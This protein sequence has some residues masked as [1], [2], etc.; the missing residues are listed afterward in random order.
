MTA[1]WRGALLLGL[2]LVGL[3]RAEPPPTSTPTPQPCLDGPVAGLACVPGGLFTRGVDGGRHPPA[4]PRARVW[5]GTFYMD[6]HEVTYGAYKACEKAGRCPKAGPNYRDFD[7][8]RQPINGVSWYD[9]KA[10]CEAHGKHLPTEAEWEKAARGPDGGLYPWG[11]A[12]ATCARAIIRDARGRSCG[13]TQRSRTHADVGRPE[14]VGSRPPNA[15][16]LYDM[17]GNA[18]EWVA[19]WYS[20][21]W[22]ACGEACQGVDPKGPCGG[23]Q[24]CPGH[25]QKVV[26]G[27]SWYWPAEYA[28]AVYRRPHVPANRPV[29]HHFGF[30]CAASLEEARALRSARP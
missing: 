3:A 4:R 2:G 19:D 8:P 22:K 15:Y 9:A 20:P 23:A 7:N 30:R 13:H 18:W 10:F 14:P 12:P 25:T 16:G 27:G 5:V 28:T 24:P 11:D 21:S 26:R 6:T 29:F 1:A 17:A